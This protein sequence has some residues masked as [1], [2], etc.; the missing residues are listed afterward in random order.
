MRI[1][2]IDVFTRKVPLLAAFKTALRTVTEVEIIDAVIHF[3]NGMKG[4]G[5][6]APSYV[7]TGDSAES[8]KAALLGPIQEAISGKN[9]F[10]FQKTLSAVQSCCAGNPSAKAAADIALH[11]AFS[12]SLEIPLWKLLGGRKPLTTCMTISADRPEKMAEDAKI[13]A[14]KGFAVLKVKVGADPEQDFERVEAIQTVLPSHIRL[15]LDANQ[16]WDPKQAVAFIRQFEKMN[17]NIELIEQP[18]AAS[19]WDGLKYVTDHSGIPIMADESLFSAKDAMKLAA[20][21]YADMLNI[22]LMKC[23]GLSEAWKIATVAQLHGVACMVGS[24]ME[25]SVSVGAAAH[26]AA[27][28]PNIRYFDLDAPLWLKEDA[29]CIQYDR[30]HVL[31]SDLPGL[32]LPAA[33]LIS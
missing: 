27:A 1:Q 19:D 31:L 12:R 20:G 30:N 8:I 26:L 5:S 16:G 18:V 29:S 3:E 9:L 15:R 32:G 2:K 33:E 17:W 10:D 7:I 14:E 22:K 24:M 23:G 25:S 28:H 21:R 11:D 6:A 4:R 13:A